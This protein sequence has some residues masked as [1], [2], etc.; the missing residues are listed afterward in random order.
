MTGAV[1]SSS[2]GPIEGPVEGPIRVIWNANAGSKAGLPTN[3]SSEQQLRELMQKHGLG[4][5]LIATESEE[6]AIAATRDAVAKGYAVVAA[7]GG[8]GTAGPIAF[9]LLGTNTALGILPLG[10]AM[11]VARSL[12]IPREL[13][14]AAEILAARRVRSIDV[15]EAN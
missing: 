13:D 15:A 5:G 9:E 12:G 6:E 2:E 14:A 11:N 3:R 1:E 7:A 4:D 8:D 10:S